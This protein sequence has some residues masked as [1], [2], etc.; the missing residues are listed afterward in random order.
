MS[1]SRG[2]VSTASAVAHSEYADRSSPLSVPKTFGAKPA[3][4]TSGPRNPFAR[5]PGMTRDRS[6]HKSTSF[7]ERVDAAEG[8]PAPK[9]KKQKQ[10]KLFGFGGSKDKDKA[11]ATRKIRP[12]PVFAD[13]GETQTTN[14]DDEEQ[15]SVRATLDAVRRESQV[16]LEETQF[17]GE[18]E[19]QADEDTQL[20]DVDVDD[21][22][23]LPDAH[24][25]MQAAISNVV[26]PV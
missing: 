15:E 3:A 12:A 22:E 11:T 4:V 1:Q 7:F 26:P 19:T 9:P 24:A 2:R 16:Q 17:V 18:E 23:E 13:F 25:A 14:D 10:T 21:D 20:N 5:N 6:M 8:E